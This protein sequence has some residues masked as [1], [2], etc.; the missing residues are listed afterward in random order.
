MSAEAGKRGPYKKAIGGVV[1]ARLAIRGGLAAMRDRGPIRWHGLSRCD[2]VRIVRRADEMRPT[3]LL[4]NI[5]AA[6]Y[7]S[8]LFNRGKLVD[9]AKLRPLLLASLP[10][11]LQQRTYV[12]MAWHGR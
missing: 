1:H 8:W 9:W 7:S 11:D 6:T 4:L 5:V 2:G 3:A 10:T 12:V